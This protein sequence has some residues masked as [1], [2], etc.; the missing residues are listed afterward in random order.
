LLDLHPI[1]IPGTRRPRDASAVR[2][3]CLLDE[4]PDPAQ[5]AHAWVEALDRDLQ[6]TAAEALLFEYTASLRSIE[7]SRALP[8]FMNYMK[9]L[10]VIRSRASIALHDYAREIGWRR[11]VLFVSTLK[12]ARRYHRIIVRDEDL[13]RSE[14]RKEFTGRLGVATVLIARFEHVDG[15]DLREAFDALERSMAQGNDQASAVPYLLEAAGRMYDVD[16]DRSRLQIAEPFLSLVERGEIP[17]AEARLAAAELLLRWLE[18]VTSGEDRLGLLGRSRAI[19]KRVRCSSGEVESIVRL[20]ILNVLVDLLEQDPGGTPEI[21]RVRIPFGFRHGGTAPQHVLA[22]MLDALLPLTRTGEPL[23]RG[24]CADLLNLR[25]L[26]GERLVAK[27]HQQIMLRSGDAN[28]RPLE[29]ER[30]RLLAARDRLELAAMTESRLLRMQALAE[31]LALSQSASAGVA[32]LVLIAKDVESHGAFEH[33]VGQPDQAW[34]NQ[35]IQQGDSSSILAAAAREALGSPDLSVAP[36]GGRGGV[37]T[38][39]DYFD[40]VGGTF[41]FKRATVLTWRREVARSVALRAWIDQAG[42][43]A[44][45]GVVDHLSPRIDEI[46][47]LEPSEVVETV[48]RFESG[49]VLAEY[50]EGLHYSDRADALAS[51]AEFLAFVHGKESEGQTP[52]GAR[53]DVLG[54]EVGRWLRALSFEDPAGTFAEFWANYSDLP[55]LRRRDAHPLNWLI[56]SGGRLLAVDLE[57]MGWRPITYEVAQLTEDGC[58]LEPADWSS[59]VAVLR[60]Y[61]TSLGLEVDATHLR[62]FESSVFARALRKLTPPTGHGSVLTHGLDTLAFLSAN[63]SHE[64]IRKLARQAGATWRRGRGLAEE[65]LTLQ[66]DLDDNKRRRISKALAYHLRHDAEMPTDAEGWVEVGTLVT[67]MPGDVTPADITLVATDFR[68]AR[69]ELEGTRI[70]ARYGHTRRARIK[71]ALYEGSAPLFHAAPMQIAARIVLVDG[72]RPMKRQFVHL[73]SDANIAAAA[74]RRHGHAVLLTASG[75]ALPGLRHAAET[76]YVSER[77][78]PERLGVVPISCLELAIHG[79]SHG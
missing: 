77:V 29:D 49:A 75:A 43:A 61:L 42:L 58:L 16:L 9:T 70:R 63:G 35:R 30:S 65:T 50:V 72:L 45:Y 68:E 67:R 69:F 7:F 25:E 32:A 56:A 59:R 12:F 36:L 19:L 71:Y 40:V 64:S 6:V 11:P 76:T 78:A 39:G 24:V 22:A 54:K 20:K 13:T 41:V 44:T 26:P 34:V 17:S 10:H 18:L 5:V 3:A 52:K 53:K 8:N 60:R 14:F 37:V 57:A 62:A 21:V 4:R 55:L 48:R 51:A 31:L 46:G 2:F 38:V 74:G 1:L 28:W 66:L 47:E 73:S 27:L 79:D 23:A 33:A 15:E